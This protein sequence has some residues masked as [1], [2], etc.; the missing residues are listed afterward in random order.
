MLVRTWLLA[1]LIAADLTDDL[2]NALGNHGTVLQA[3]G[4]LPEAEKC[5]RENVAIRRRLVQVEKRSDMAHHLAWALG[6]HGLLLQALGRLPE[7]GAE[8]TRAATLTRNERE[9]SLLL[10]RAQA[11]GVRP[12]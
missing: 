8:F 1:H 4:R 2:A 9:R 5:Q 6:H 7:A 12:C 11:C 3:Q 10:E